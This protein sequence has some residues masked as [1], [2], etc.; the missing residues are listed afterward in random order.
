MSEGFRYGVT[1]T[2]AETSSYLRA[3][4]SCEDHSGQATPQVAHREAPV[5][6]GLGSSSVEVRSG[7]H[8]GP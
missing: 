2:G 1:G 7:R 5:W 8:S 6:S 4:R 3:Y